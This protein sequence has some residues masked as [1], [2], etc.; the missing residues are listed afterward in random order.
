MKKMIA[1][2]T[3]ALLAAALA[4]CNVVQPPSLPPASS[5][6]AAS[7]SMPAAPD[8][9]AAQSLQPAGVLRAYETEG[10][11]Q[12]HYDGLNTGVAL[13]EVISE[14]TGDESPESALLWR[15]DYS[16]RQQAVLCGEAGC[17]HSDEGCTAF[18]PTY[19][20]RHSLLEAAGGLVLVDRGEVIPVFEDE[21]GPA[22][23]YTYLPA[24]L[25]WM[26]YDGTGRRRLCELGEQDQLERGWITDDAF[27]YCIRTLPAEDMTAPDAEYNK[28]RA[29]LKIDLAS[30]EVAVLCQVD[31][32][33]EFF[34]GVL[35][36]ALLTR[37]IEYP[38]DNRELMG[39]ENFAAWEEN[40]QASRMVHYAIDP[41][42]GER[43]RL[44]K[45]YPSVGMG[46]SALDGEYFYYNAVED[47]VYNQGIESV[48]SS[49]QPIYKVHLPTGET[50]ELVNFGERHNVSTGGIFG[51]KLSV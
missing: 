31:P 32:R 3:A 37:R 44:P 26:N 33:E 1:L 4:G 10:M 8:T 42:T 16:T 21:Y 2:L 13:Y 50:T 41:E 39:E 28:D 40:M 49:P 22:T 20:S 25:S 6:E 12:T 34:V 7:A 36:G 30:G 46:S 5:G 17:T 27:L 38:V 47:F 48:G 29:I 23:S 51:G 15:T 19:A 11:P 14:I 45:D 35:N 43:T 24:T 9:P 18:L